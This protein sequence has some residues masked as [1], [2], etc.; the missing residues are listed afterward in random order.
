MIAL[1]VII[2]IVWA[3]IVSKHF[4][5]LVKNVFI[6]FLAIFVLYKIAS[7]LDWIKI[8]KGYTPR[9]TIEQPQSIQEEELDVLLEQLDELIRQQRENERKNEIWV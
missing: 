2:A 1:F 5:N 6:I 8:E 3:L 4:R 9:P 7:W